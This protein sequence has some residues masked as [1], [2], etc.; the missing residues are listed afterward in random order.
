MRAA[1]SVDGSRRSITASAYVQFL[2]RLLQRLQQAESLRAMVVDQVG[3]DFGVG[4][5]GE[6]VAERA[7]AVALLLMVL[8]DAVVDQREVAVADVRMR[9]AFG[10]AAVRGP[11]RVADAEGGVEALGDRRGFHLGD[12]AGAAHAAHGFAI[13]HRDAGGIVAAVF[14]PLEPIDQQRDHITIG[15][16]TDDSAHAGNSRFDAE[17]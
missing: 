17:V 14:Q 7:Q 3:D 12:A 13:D 2:D 9:V 16:G 6:L 8:D 5:R 15:D 10:D 1:T 11:A 4:L